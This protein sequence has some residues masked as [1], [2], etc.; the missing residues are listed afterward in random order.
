M[1]LSAMQDTHI[2]PRN[3]PPAATRSWRAARVAMKPPAKMP[4]AEPTMYAVSA[5]EASAA[6]TPYC[7]VIAVTLKVCSPARPAQ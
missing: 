7:T 2:A 3:S 4:A 1:R 6:V 5:L